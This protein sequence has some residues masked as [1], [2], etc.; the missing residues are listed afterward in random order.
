M[1]WNIVAECIS[2]INLIIIWF[3]SR[4]S[5]LVPS[6]KNRLF[7]TCFLVTFCAMAFNIASTVMLAYPDKAPY[8]LT[9][10]VTGIYFAATP[11]MGMTYFF[12]TVATVFENSGNATKIMAWTSLPGCIYL[13]LVL[14][15]PFSKI[16]FDITKAGEYSQG[17][18][19]S[20][21]YVVFYL[22]CVAAMVAVVIWKKHV[23]QAIRRILAAF[24]FIAML[25]II[26]QQLYPTVILSGS[27]ATCALLIIYLYLQNKQNSVDYLTGLPNRQEFLKM[28]ELLIKKSKGFN[29]TVLSLRGFRRINDTYGQHYG[30]IF[31]QKIAGYLKSISDPH[32]LYRYGGDEFAILSYGSFDDS[33]SAKVE[34]LEQRM[35][36]FWALGENN[37]MIPAVIGVVG[38]PECAGTVE[39]LINGIEFSVSMAKESQESNVYYCGPEMLAS[40]K[41]RQQVVETL[42]EH[43]KNNSFSVYYQPIISMSTGKYTVAESLLRIPDSPLGPLYP[44]EFIPIAEETGMIVEITYQVL[45]KV[46]KFINRLLEDGIEFDGVHVNFSG[47]QFSQLGLAE[48]VEKIIEENQTPFSKIKIE[49]TESILAENADAVAEFALKMQKR[50]VLIELDD[51]GTGYSNIVSVMNTPLDTVKLDKSIIWSAMEKK[52][53]AVMVKSLTTVFHQMGL[54]VLAEGVEDAEQEA[55]VRDSGIDY[56]Q[57]FYFSRPLPEEEAFQFIKKSCN[58]KI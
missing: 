10:L 38:Y 47:H 29:V 55:F 23:E 24:P 5:N 7:Q 28:M 44:N 22:Y 26:V 54:Q 3:Y 49:I 11:L 12:Y 9:W 50:G 19:I 18:L 2:A 16:L 30:D 1:H 52:E 33:V 42:E 25:V 35:Q 20:L 46:C 36:E 4:K 45:D 14:W 57:G 58:I 40:V 17:P 43:L 48:K 8:V 15:N 27:A 21:T 53:A 34:K 6:L 32:C 56:I 39:E 37:C 31:L 51:F 41:R 13:V